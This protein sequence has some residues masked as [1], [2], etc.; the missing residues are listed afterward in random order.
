ML[1]I[2]FT[3][4]VSF[5]GVIFIASG[6]E[7]YLVKGGELGTL[8]RALSVLAGVLLLTPD[9]TTDLIGALLAAILVA[10]SL[11]RSKPD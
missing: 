6:L 11:L 4:L 2:A 9:L 5:F 3:T 8:K 10:G 7:G 1:Q